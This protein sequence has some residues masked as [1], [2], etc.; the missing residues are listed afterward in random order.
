MILLG[1]EAA[2]RTGCLPDWRGDGPAPDVDL[3]GSREEFAELVT[4]LRAHYPVVV[5]VDRGG[6][7]LSIHAA[8][9]D[10]SR[11]L[12]D[13]VTD[14]LASS[15]AVIALT[16][17]TDGVI[18]DRPVQ[19]ISPLTQLVIKRA[20]Q[21]FPIKRENNDRDIAFW[22]QLVGDE[23]W[24]EAHQAVFDTLEAEYASRF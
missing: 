21:A 13:W 8:A 14:E 11:V 7:R 12:V 19:V 17:H 20:Y 15:Q 18:F 16:D 10:G 2:R 6:V 22:S 9:N 3:L 1:G 24:S 23:P 4:W 5:P